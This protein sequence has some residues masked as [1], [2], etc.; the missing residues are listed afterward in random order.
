MARHFFLAALGL[1]SGLA[2]ADEAA[3]FRTWTDSRQAR[4]EAAL[5]GVSDGVATLKLRAG[6]E[7]R[8]PV[9]RL[10]PA[11]QAWL[12]AREGSAPPPGVAEAPQAAADW[13]RVVQ[14]KAAPEVRTV[15]EDARERVF[16]YESEHYEFVCD[17][18]LSANLAREFS[19]VFEATWLANC[20]L[21]LDLQPAPEP[22]RGKFQARIFTKEEDYLGAGGVK[23]SAG[24]YDRQARALMLPLASLGVQMVGSRVSINYLA[25]DYATLAHEI[26]HQMMNHW[27][28][29]LPV[30]FIEGS[31]EYIELAEY[32][33]GRLSFL[34]HDARL[35]QQLTRWSGAR[36]DMVPL[37]R[38]LTIEGREWTSALGQ[39]EAAWRNYA[40]ALALTYYFYHLDG[41][42]TGRQMVEFLRAVAKLE[43]GADPTPLVAQYLLR[44]RDDA[45]LESDVQKAFR[46]KRIIIEFAD[47]PA[48]P[49]G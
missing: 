13:P 43:R 46:K 10:S 9:S 12:A 39:D 45:A 19:R 36:F 35:Q 30:W 4:I 26:T 21:P 14:L 42:G 3:D 2:L 31:A 20:L 17:S 40:S 1:A 33:N 6:G 44:G 47:A 28:D 32:D 16:I 7:L 22:G 29:R 37:R 24:I 5:A 23:G 15:R 48:P 11:D 41:D 25:E 49:R 34:R 27:L 38:L 18:Q 8:V